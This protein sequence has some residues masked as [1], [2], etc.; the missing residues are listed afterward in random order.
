M[1]NQDSRAHW[2]YDIFSFHTFHLEIPQAFA[3]ILKDLKCL[4]A[5]L[6]TLLWGLCF[7]QEALLRSKQVCWLHQFEKISRDFVQPSTKFQPVNDWSPGGIYQFEPLHLWWYL[8]GQQ[9]QWCGAFECRV[10]QNGGFGKDDERFM[11]QAWLLYQGCVCSCHFNVSILF[12]LMVLMLLCLFCLN[13]W[14]SVETVS[15]RTKKLHSPVHSENSCCDLGHQG[16][17]SMCF[18][19]QNAKRIWKGRFGLTWAT[20][21]FGACVARC[22]LTNRF[23]CLT[24]HEMSIHPQPCFH[25]QMAQSCERRHYAL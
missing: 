13:R 22:F 25:H 12:L 5:M 21:S 6:Y 7:S 10:P 17:I 11:S 1:S 24:K 16:A 2:E 9:L 18:F 4:V 14:L 3:G 20:R 15:L 19:S 23:W 8:E